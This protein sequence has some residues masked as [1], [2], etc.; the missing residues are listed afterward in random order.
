MHA[1][2]GYQLEALPLVRRFVRAFG[3]P[4]FDAVVAPVGLVRGDGGAT[5]TG[6]WRS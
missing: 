3:D 6:G 4:T 2:S 1:N 5:S